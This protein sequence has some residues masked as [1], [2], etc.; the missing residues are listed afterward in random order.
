MSPRAFENH[1][2]PPASPHLRRACDL[3]D[4]GQPRE[5]EFVVKEVGKVITPGV[6]IRRAERIRRNVS[7][8]PTRVKPLTTERQIESGR[9]SFVRE[10]VRPPWFTFEERDG[11][12]FV[13]LASMPPRVARDRAA[14]KAGEQIDPARIIEAAQRGDDVTMLLHDAT[15]ATLMRVTLALAEH[16]ANEQQ[17]G[18]REQMP[19]WADARE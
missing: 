10:V 11:K 7:N 16:V 5:W 13:R 9:R 19:Q 8:S 1:G 12:R 14:E 18:R 2:G 3:L 17:R 4:D 6:A 15:R